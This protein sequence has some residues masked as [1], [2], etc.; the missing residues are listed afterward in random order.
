MKQKRGS[1]RCSKTRFVL[2]IAG[3]LSGSMLLAVLPISAEEPSTRLPNGRS[4]P[5]LFNW[6]PG[7]LDNVPADI[8]RKLQPRSA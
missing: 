8:Q 1:L 4:L 6:L 3:V 5:P 7:E 2:T